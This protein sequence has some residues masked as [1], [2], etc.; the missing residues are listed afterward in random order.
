MLD[1][2]ERLKEIIKK[3][4]LSLNKIALI[5]G[6]DRR[7]INSYLQ[8]NND[9]FLS[10][11]LRLKICEYFRYP[12]E[13]W[14]S[15]NKTFY[16]LL[17]ELKESEL[18]IIDEGSVG[19]LKYLVENENEGMLILNHRFPNSVYKYLVLDFVYKDKDNEEINLYRKKRTE[20][21]RDHSFNLSE[22][23][24]IKSLLEFC[25]ANV[26]NFYTKEQKIAILDFVLDNFKD[27]FNKNLYFFD[28]YAKKNYGLDSF[29]V[30]INAKENFLFFKAP[31]ETML[32]EIRNSTLVQK[33][34]RHYTDAKECPPHVQGKEACFILELLKECINKNLNIKQSCELI[35]EKTPY[36]SLFL[37]ALSTEL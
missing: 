10:E 15:D 5:L 26:G 27:N 12:S 24:P 7:T 35:N 33:L 21:I 9:K 14:Y 30:C 31:I 18:K 17:N 1:F 20:K 11:E 34:H 25:F 32:V 23:Y 22:W 16:Q 13:I 3:S 36:G 6:K 28:S 37:K 2:K 4:G 8:S 19:Q 29:Y